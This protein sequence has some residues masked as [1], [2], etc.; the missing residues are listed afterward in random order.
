MG[1]VA[2]QTLKTLKQLGV[3]ATRAELVDELVVVDGLLLAVA[4][5]AALDIPGG[6]DLGMGCA[7]EG[8]L[9]E[10]GCYGVWGSHG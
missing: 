4:G 7:V 5:D 10:G 9:C 3:D 2:C 1:F 6:D 8:C